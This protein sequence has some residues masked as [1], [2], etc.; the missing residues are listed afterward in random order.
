MNKTFGESIT[1]SIFHSGH[2]HTNKPV[3]RYWDHAGNFQCGQPIH[4]QMVVHFSSK[5]SLA[6]TT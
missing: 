2:I 4:I 3:S 6:Q 5:Y 1:A